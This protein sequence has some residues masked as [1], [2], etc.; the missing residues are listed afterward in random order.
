CHGNSP[1]KKDTHG[2]GPQRPVITCEAG[3]PPLGPVPRHL[4]VNRETATPHP[5]G[6][7]AARTMT[8]PAG[9]EPN[10]FH[11]QRCSANADALPVSDGP[12]GSSCL[13]STGT[14]ATAR[15]GPL[16]ETETLMNCP[17]CGGYGATGRNLQT[18]GGNGA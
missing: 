12:G 3:S 1:L 14:G 2:P 4:P 10:P 9:I 5:A 17:C 18:T 13:P 8:N 7:I 15:T 11:C 16:V 6:T